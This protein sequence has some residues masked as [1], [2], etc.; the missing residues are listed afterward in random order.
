MKKG[1]IKHADIHLR[2]RTLIAEAGVRKLRS[3]T[4]TIK[5]KKGPVPKIRDRYSLKVGSP[6]ILTGSPIVWVATSNNHL[7]RGIVQKSFAGLG[8]H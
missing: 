8:V 7:S 1:T 3:A 5:M 2:I 4:E 6:P